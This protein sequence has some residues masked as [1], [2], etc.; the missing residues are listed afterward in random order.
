MLR[1]KNPKSTFLGLLPQGPYME[2]IFKYIKATFFIPART[3][4]S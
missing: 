2:K 1:Y 3:N 4:F